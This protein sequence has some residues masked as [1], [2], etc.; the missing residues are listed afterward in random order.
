MEIIDKIPINCCIENFL[1][2]YHQQQVQI[3]DADLR[4]WVLAQAYY[5]GIKIEVVKK[6]EQRA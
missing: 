4:R 3:P 5:Y 6:V 2:R 1:N